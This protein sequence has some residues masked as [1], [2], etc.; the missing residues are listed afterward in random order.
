[1]RAPPLDENQTEELQRLWRLNVPASQIGTAIGS[2]RQTVLKWATRHN[3]PRRDIPT[4]RVQLPDLF[5]LWADHTLDK[6]QVAKLLGITTLHLGRLASKH[7]LGGRPREYK[8]R[9]TVDPT[10]A[11]I[12]EL[13]REVR[14]RHMAMRRAEKW[15]PKA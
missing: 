7:K 12:E 13:K 11:E 4:N 9:M 1:M 3:L 15:E 8:A 6:A 5:R 2:N 14:E 10:P